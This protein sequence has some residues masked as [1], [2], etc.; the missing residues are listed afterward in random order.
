MAVLGMYEFLLKVSKLKKTQE[1]VDN[2]AGNDTFAL[3]TIL[4]GVFDPTVKFA[5]PEGE[6]PYRPNEIVDQQ[7][8]L[9]READKI[10][11][12][13]EGFYPNLNQSKR[14][15]MFVEFLERLDPDDA[16]LI[17]AMKDK[18]MPFPGIT[19]QH[20]KEALP[21]LIQE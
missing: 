5:L 8:I 3:R 21:G 10:R 2:L 11:Y 9:H 12:F 13:V 15:M 17:L 14:E 16:K 7:H 4:Q 1:K 19:I 20:V 18:K 6:P